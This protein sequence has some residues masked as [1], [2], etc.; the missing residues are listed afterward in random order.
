MKRRTEKQ[1]D[2][3]SAHVFVCTNARDSEYAACADVGGEATAAAVTSWLRERNAYWSPIG[4]STTDCL[5]LCS[6]EGTAIT[7]QP[8]NE[9][10]AEVQPADVPALLTDMFGSEADEIEPPAG[11]SEL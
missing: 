1:T 6:S 10:Y 3:L 5:G 9:W 2:R 8:Q 4:V 11:E 7:I